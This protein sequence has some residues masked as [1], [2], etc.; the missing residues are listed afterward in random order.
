MQKICVARTNPLSTSDRSPGASGLIQLAG[1]PRNP[2]ITS[3]YEY[4]V[5]C[6]VDFQHTFFSPRMAPERVRLC[7]SVA[8]GERVLVLFAG[9]GMEALQIVAK[10]E[11]MDVLAIEQNEVAA[12][13]LRRAR[14]MLERNKTV[15][16][17]GGGNGAAERLNIMEGDALE[18]LPTLEK[19]S[20]DRI[21]AP[22]P[23]EGTMDGDLGTGDAGKEFLLAMLP[24]LKEKGE[25][26]WYDFAA[27]HELPNCNRTRETVQT[28]CQTLGLTMDVIHIAKVGSVAK[29]QFRVCMDFR[30]MARNE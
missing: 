22:R 19:S 21:I 12:E 15:T 28:V 8:R 14:R 26:H 11:A 16:V 6:V 29:R 13:C 25:V 18:I 27:D 23:K 17:P 4:G 7:Q 5:K 9:V 10:T 20:F 30:I 3:H 1:P 24:L 2:L